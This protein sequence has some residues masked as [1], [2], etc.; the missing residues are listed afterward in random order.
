MNTTPA[1]RPLRN[2]VVLSCCLVLLAGCVSPRNGTSVS[3]SAVEERAVKARLAEILQAA[4]T[5]DLARLDSYH[6]YGSHFTKFASAGKRMN[7]T[8][9]REGE[10]KGLT[11][12][13]D[14]KLSPEDLK[15]DVFGSTAIATFLARARFQSGAE[16]ISKSERATLVFVKYDG[17]WKIVHEHL[18]PAE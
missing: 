10:H 16:T 15:I 4:E 9:A 6:W 18:S 5:K 11:A 3:S 8:T 1:R 14:L 12:V 17:S 7:A 13:A 2:C